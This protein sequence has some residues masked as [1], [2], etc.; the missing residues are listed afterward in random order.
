MQ[1]LFLVIVLLQH[2]VKAMIGFGFRTFL[3]GEIEAAP[4][5]VTLALGIVKVYVVLY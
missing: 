4:L 1:V 5:F 3:G 2:L